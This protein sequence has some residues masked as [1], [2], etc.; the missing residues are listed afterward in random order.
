MKFSIT[1]LLAV[2]L[3]SGAFAQKN[4][5]IAGW[6]EHKTFVFRAQ[7]ATA[8][9]GRTVQLTTEY[10]VDVSPDA[11]VAYLPYFGRAYSAPIG[12]NDGGIKFTSKDYSYTVKQRKKGG[13]DV[14]LTPKDAKGV[15]QL[16]FSISENG[17]ASLQ[18][19]SQNRQPISFYG[20][21]LEPKTK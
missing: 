18:V 11:A 9:R 15:R 3:I 21:I 12:T 13:W 19:T 1:L 8:M 10:R 2:S 6:I 16:F 17:Y 7:S 20:T 14:T 5:A 4:D